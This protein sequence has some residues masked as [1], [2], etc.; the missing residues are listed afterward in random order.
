M[1]KIEVHKVPVGFN[2]LINLLWDG[3]LNENDFT[4]QASQIGTPVAQI[5]REILELKQA[6]GV[7]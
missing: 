3:K 1:T 7:A 5:E 4:A 2:D 6:D